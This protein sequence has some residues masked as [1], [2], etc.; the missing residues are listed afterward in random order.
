LSW[1]KLIELDR[2][3]AVVLVTVVRS[4]VKLQ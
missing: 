3:V 4:V 2:V 1:I